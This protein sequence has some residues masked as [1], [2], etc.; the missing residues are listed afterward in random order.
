MARL[1]ASKWVL[2]TS[3]EMPG[4]K[5]VLIKLYIVHPSMRSVVNDLAI[6]DKSR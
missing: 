1:S 6:D 5:V 4:L 3:R 2:L